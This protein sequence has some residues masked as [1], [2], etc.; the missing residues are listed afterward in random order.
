[1][2]RVDEAE[3]IDAAGTATRRAA[4]RIGLIDTGVNP[5]HS[6]VKGGVYGCRIYLDG[7]GGI[8]EDGE[9]CDRL[10]HGT[11]VAAILRQQVPDAEI[12]AVKVFESGFT[13]YPSL[14]AR[15]VL[16]AAAEGCDFVNL[17]LAMPPGPGSELLALACAEAIAAGCVVVAAGH[18]GKG[19]L[20]PASIPGVL[21]VVADDLV[22]DG[23]IRMERGRPYPFAAAGRPRDL[24]RQG[25]SGN[26]FGNSFACARVTAYLA[27]RM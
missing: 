1:M 24:E 18:P 15:A 21:G 4:V 23:E 26:L 13:T 20:L 12:F 9:I 17:S 27:A 14:V 3:M 25:I 6:H 11:A 22:P 16:R 7:D 10:G 5:W 2:Q 8:R 19:D